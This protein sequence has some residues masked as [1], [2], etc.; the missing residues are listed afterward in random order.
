MH[1]RWIT[2]LLLVPNP[3]IGRVDAATLSGAL[4]AAEALGDRKL[5]GQV[6]GEVEATRS[7][8]F[9]TPVQKIAA[10]PLGKKFDPLPRT[11]LGEAHCVE[12]IV[13]FCPT[14][15]SLYSLAVM[16]LC[17]QYHIPITAV[18]L[19]R[20]NLER[21]R[22]EFSRDGTRLLRKVWRKL[23]LRADENSEST[24]VS[25][26][27]V[28]DQ[29]NC[30]FSDVRAFARHLGV[31][32]FEVD[33]FS[34]P[35]KGLRLIK[36]SRALHTGGGLIREPMLRHFENGVINVHMG[37]LPQY[38]G[39][40]VVQAPILDGCFDS[41]GVS[42]HL[43]ALGLDEG[44]AVSVLTTSSTAYPS[45]GALRNELSALIPLMSFDACLGLASGRYQ[46]EPQPQ[47]G[48]QYYVIHHALNKLIP[49]VMGHRQLVS[50]TPRGIEKIVEQALN[51]D[52]D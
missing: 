49:Q 43:M 34:Q 28:S 48:R 44:P 13:L 41:V 17:N 24:S 20:M 1:L 37:C 27:S 42:A 29:L 40:D 3:T 7:W 9:E 6:L 15:M 21:F 16:Q 51:N 45:L 19:R 52:G 39:M 18:V 22:Q 25:L 38:K 14:P 11:W 36:G 4:F 8:L 32:V 35:P 31:P 12:P 10:Q 5:M 23:V 47:Y 26:K 30:G 33:N 50:S 2:E 46:A